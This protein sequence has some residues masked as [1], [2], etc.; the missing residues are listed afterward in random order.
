MKE[1]I[2]I[3]LLLS[4]G[5]VASAQ[6]FST[7]TRRSKNPFTDDMY[8]VYARVTTVN[9][10]F[11]PSYTGFTFNFGVSSNEYQLGGHRIRYE[12]PTIGDLIQGIPRW[13]KDLKAIKNDEQTH[14]TVNKW[15]DHAHG[16]GILGWFQWYI[17]AVSKDRFLLSPG[18]SLGD[19][20]YGSRYVK[21]IGEDKKDQDPYGYFFAAGPA[22]MASYVVSKSCWVDAYV[23]YDLMFAKVKNRGTEGYPNPHFLTVGADFHTTSKFFGGVR[24]NKLKDR[25]DNKDGSAR[26]DISAGILF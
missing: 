14:V 8:K 6:S 16:G 11:T 7:L 18:I 19:Y 4:T 5:C 2:L 1:I 17:N 25:G 12:N 13:L 9:S 23:N 20:M 22:I 21:S 24:L 26:L 15:D 3:A 10:K